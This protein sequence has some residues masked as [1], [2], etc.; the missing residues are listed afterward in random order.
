MSGGLLG[1]AGVIVVVFPPLP[2]F[3]GVHR[4]VQRQQLVLR[5]RQRDHSWKRRERRGAGGLRATRR[6]HAP[7][8]SRE[9]RRGHSMARCLPE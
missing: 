4:K 7:V 5:V 3:P 9:A 1:Q 6:R 8:P 2:V